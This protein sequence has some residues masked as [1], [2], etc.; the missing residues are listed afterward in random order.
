MFIF[1]WGWGGGV[2]DSIFINNLFLI[3]LFYNVKVFG[4]LEKINYFD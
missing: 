2:G 1:G 3:M 4:C